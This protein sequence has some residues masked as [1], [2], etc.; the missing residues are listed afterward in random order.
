MSDIVLEVLEDGTIDRNNYIP[1]LAVNPRADGAYV[2]SVTGWIEATGALADARYFVGPNGPA[3]RAS[4]AVAFRVEEIVQAGIVDKQHLAQSVVDLLDKVPVSGES[5]EDG[6]AI[7]Q[8]NGQTISIALNISELQILRRLETV[9]TG[10][11]ESGGSLHVTTKSPANPSGA[12]T[13]LPLTPTGAQ[14]A[15]TTQQVQD[16]AG[17]EIAKALLDVSYNPATNAYSGKQRTVSGPIAGEP[18]VT[19]DIADDNVTEPKLSADVRSKLNS[20]RGA[21]SARKLLRLNAVPT[22]TGYNV[23]EI[24]DVNGVLYELVGATD[25]A[26]VVNFTAGHDGQNYVGFDNIPGDPNYGSVAGG[27][28]INFEWAPDAEGVSLQRARIQ[29]AQASAAPQTLYF[30]IRGDTREELRGAAVMRDAGRDESLQDGRD[31]YAYQSGATGDRY[32][33]GSGHKGT[34]SLYSDEALT[35]PIPLHTANRWEEWLPRQTGVP[36]VPTVE[37]IEQEAAAAARARYT[38]DEKAKLRGIAAGANVGQTAQQVTAAIRAF[39]RASVSNAQA[40][41]GLIEILN[42][43]PYQ[44]SLLGD[45]RS[46]FSEGSLAAYIAALSSENQPALRTAL[47]PYLPSL[48]SPTSVASQPVTSANHDRTVTL[49]ARANLG[50]TGRMAVFTYTGADYS[51]SQTYENQDGVWMTFAIPLRG[52]AAG[53]TFTV[54]IRS[55][56]AEN[57]VMLQRTGSSALP[58]G[59]YAVKTV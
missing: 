38:D 9:V 47:Q 25:D 18:V 32:T 37:S 8:E 58:H 39:A 59:T 43:D 10:V 17:A 20:R 51:F 31:F 14:N 2:L 27:V 1:L 36:S 41:A 50:E 54:E 26:H 49:S 46:V 4:D 29:F 55:R 7:L 11:T 24:I 45:L 34:L 33:L 35:R 22:T 53:D 15:L 21:A 16:L 56:M 57:D 19:A 12:P 42:T 48:P 5:R 23:G 44:G 13:T 40:K 30:V 6:I 52:G 3:T 28:T